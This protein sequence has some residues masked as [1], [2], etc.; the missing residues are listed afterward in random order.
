ME[1]QLRKQRRKLII[2]I[3]AILFAVWFAISAAYSVICYNNAK[4]DAALIQDGNVNN[5]YHELTA[6]DS[7]S[8]DYIN[9]YVFNHGYSP[10]YGEEQFNDINYHM[11]L[12]DMD[13]N[14][15]ADSTNIL[16]FEFKYKLGSES[17]G[18]DN[19]YIKYDKFINSIT[20]EQ[21]EKIAKYL[22]SDP[23]E[24][25]SYELSCIK[26]MRGNEDDFI[27]LTL[28]IILTEPDHTWYVEDEHIET[29]ELNVDNTEQNYEW[30]EEV[31][32]NDIVYE[33]GDMG[34]NI[35]PREFFFGDFGNDDIIGMLDKAQKKQAQQN[36]MVQI[37]PFEYIY[38]QEIVVNY[39]IVNRVTEDGVELADYPY[40][41][42]YAQK[43]NIL[44]I[45]SGNIIRAATI[46]LIFF[47]VI[48]TI[49]SV[50]M[51]RLLKT[52]LI[53]EQKRV[54]I[55]NALAH[56][57][58]TPLFVISGYAQNLKDNVNTDKREHYAYKIMQQTDSVNELVHRMLELSRLDSV[59][60]KT[61]PES[62]DL[63]ELILEINENFLLLP[64]GKYIDFIHDG[65]CMI[66]A[67]MELIKC[68]V[69]NLVDNAVKYSLPYSK[70]GIELKN[71]T[72]SISNPCD[73]LSKSDLEQI[74]EPYT[75]LNQN[76][77]QN[78]TGLGLTIVKTICE[79]HK[80]KYGVKL[81]NDLIVFTIKF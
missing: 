72:L 61:K 3:S 37:S 55:T 76:N 27:P 11:I 60:L 9:N 65:E 17:Y 52:Q 29:F 25:K 58:K 24:G 74:W 47:A 4:D 51:W 21:R 20:A 36:P 78:G 22:N 75:R 41:F 49:M 26:Y 56:D 7:I 13:R 39:K 50:M 81:K 59:Y 34:K 66:T 2:R 48:G 28:Q 68:V 45:C 57:I 23:G 46:L 32:L 16:G 79:L 62:F 1:K 12:R 5:I 67:D 10:E 30:G 15:I 80:L 63:T 64:D 44:D 42:M 40:T 43:L 6:V 71:K 8:L 53:A 38:Y 35:I 19:S 69:E 31:E 70:I 54:N 33:I 18:Y 77:R 14:I 73:N